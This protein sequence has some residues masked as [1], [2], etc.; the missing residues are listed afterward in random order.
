ML[1]QKKMSNIMYFNNILFNNSPTDLDYSP[2][3]SSEIK[4]DIKTFDSD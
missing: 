2:N 3:Q 4:V 1:S